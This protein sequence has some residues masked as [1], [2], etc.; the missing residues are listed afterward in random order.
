MMDLRQQIEREAREASERRAAAYILSSN[1]LQELEIRNRPQEVQTFLR[2]PCFKCGVRGDI[3][4]EHQ[5]PVPV[6]P[7]LEY[8][9]RP[10]RAGDGL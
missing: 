6:G 5:K 9:K 8:Q 1:A 7:V 10:A 3:G 4:C 2:D